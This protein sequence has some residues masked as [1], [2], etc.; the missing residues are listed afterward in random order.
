MV[1]FISLCSSLLA[2]FRC[3]EHPNGRW[4]VQAYH[5]V[6]CNGEDEHQAMAVVGGVACLVPSGFLAAC[7]W[8]PGRVKVMSYKPR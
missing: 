4:T 2:P 1:F 5:A 6:Y 3:N 8:A 7:M